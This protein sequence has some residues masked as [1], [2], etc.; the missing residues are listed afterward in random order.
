MDTPSLMNTNWLAV[1]HGIYSYIQC[2]NTRDQA[3]LSL[4]HQDRGSPTHL[5]TE[6][7][8]RTLQGRSHIEFRGANQPTA[9]NAL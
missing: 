4:L 2:A 1:G 6:L 7:A 3:R 5:F 8:L 9:L